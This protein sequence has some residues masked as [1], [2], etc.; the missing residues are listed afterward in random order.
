[1]RPTL[2]AVAALLLVRPAAS[3][4]P[5]LRLAAVEL[6]AS[7][8]TLP[9]RAA[10]ILLVHRSG[11]LVMVDADAKQVVCVKPTSGQ[12]V[13]QGAKGSGPG[14]YRDLRSIA[15]SNAGGLAV[16]DPANARI[17]IIRPDWT[18]GSTIRLMSGFEQLIRVAGDTIVAVQAVRPWYVGVID[19]QSG[20][21]TARF[22]PAPTDSNGLVEDPHSGDWSAWVLA[23]S[24]GG[25]LVAS[26]WRYRLSRFDARG[27]LVT[28][29][30]RA[31]PPELPS[32]AEVAQRRAQMLKMNAGLPAEKQGRL[33]QLVD[34]YAKA[35]KPFAPA[36]P[37][38]DRDGRVWVV[39]PRVRDDSTELDVFSRAGV[40]TAT[41]RVPGTIEA[42]AF[43]GDRLY[44][45][46]EQLGGE[47]EGEQGVRAFREH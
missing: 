44:V 28:V 38:V 23:T 13:R 16:Y 31:I 27:H 14:E 12:A 37:A 4:T 17:T 5:T 46:G 2:A 9:F 7:L 11:C 10:P 30:Q 18:V 22:T 33:M 25:A 41:V 15:L 1:M 24:G 39:T 26:A 34:E 47:H 19:R 21:F 3:Q 40:F 45:L 42:I 29:M 6:P 8:A 32:K 35:A 36:A 43:E 20:T